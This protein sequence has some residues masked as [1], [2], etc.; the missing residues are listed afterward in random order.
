MPTT[1][2]RGDRRLAST[3]AEQRQTSRLP[4]RDWK[5]RAMTPLSPAWD[6]LDRDAEQTTLR[7]DDGA[8]SDLPLRRK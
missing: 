4:Y 7:G 5:P 8:T 3:E 6:V 1:D 2:A